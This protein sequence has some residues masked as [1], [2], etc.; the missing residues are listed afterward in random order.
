MQG[1]AHRRSYMHE[2]RD[3]GD[4]YSFIAVD[5]TLDPGPRRPFNFVGILNDPEVNKIKKFADDALAAGSKY[6]VWYCYN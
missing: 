1:K 5:A 4:L 6:I 3:D 2:V